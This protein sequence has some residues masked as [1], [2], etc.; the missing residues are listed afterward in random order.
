MVVQKACTD[1][2]AANL[3]LGF[4]D[5]EEEGNNEEDDEEEYFFASEDPFRESKSSDDIGWKKDIP[6]SDD[7]PLWS[8][9]TSET[10][11]CLQVL[12]T[13][14]SDRFFKFQYL[15]LR[16]AHYMKM[17]G[18]QVPP[19][20]VLMIQPQLTA[21]TPLAVSPSLY[22]ANSAT[23]ISARAALGAAIPIVL[24]TVCLRA[25]MMAAT[26]TPSGARR[27]MARFRTGTTGTYL[28]SARAARV[29]PAAPT[30][31]LASTPH[32]AA[33]AMAQTSLREAIARRQRI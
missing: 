20:G 19:R 29:A 27:N 28:A 8:I 14:M 1:P 17:C 23:R 16:T 24:R 25:A 5:L 7:E 21:P 33:W 31:A 2:T 15:F 22:H 13:Q 9:V 12:C 11:R 4:L 32:D 18:A 30:G 26:A 3:N 6:A 10:S